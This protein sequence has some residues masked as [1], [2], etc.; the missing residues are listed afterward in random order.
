MEEVTT[1]GLDLAK[2]VFRVH[3]VDAG[4]AIVIR[5]QLRRSQV[6]PFFRKLGPVWSGLKPAPVRITGHARS[7]P[8]VM[9]FG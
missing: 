4:G 8:W 9:R 3:G 5:R 6:L 1:I 7:E 2:N